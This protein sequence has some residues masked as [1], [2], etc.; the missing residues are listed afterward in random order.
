MRRFFWGL[1]LMS[2]FCVA[3]DE[4]SITL[5]LAQ[6]KKEEQELQQQLA[7]RRELRKKLLQQEPS[8][9]K[10][11]SDRRLK[12]KQHYETRYKEPDEEHIADC[13]TCQKIFCG[14]KKKEQG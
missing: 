3:M 14:A 6:L 10:K 8:V 12:G 5:R 9:P 11:I 7:Q 2:S 4:A 13:P 1:V